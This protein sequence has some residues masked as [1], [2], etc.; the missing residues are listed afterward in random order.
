MDK[1][2]KSFTLVE[3]LIVATIIVVLS[4]TT[5]AIF[6][7]Y[8]DDRILDNQTQLFVSILELAKSKAAAGDVSLCS[9][10][11]NAHVDGYV[12]TVD[13]TVTK[14]IEIIPG[15][16]TTPTPIYYTI[17][18]NLVYNPTTFSTQFDSS[19]YQGPTEK[20]Y[21]R[22]TGTAKC[23]YVQIDETGLITN[24]DTTCP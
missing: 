8:R 13:S 22:N 20:Y 19:N 15:C 21:I 24:G 9:D 18:D 4:G 12:V 16:D 10:S 17:P 7:T 3:I 23:K 2:K 1:N 11:A 6:S 14:K 5:L